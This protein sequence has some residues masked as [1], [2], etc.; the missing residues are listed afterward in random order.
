MASRTPLDPVPTPEPGRR[1]KRRREI[2]ADDIQILPIEEFTRE[3]STKGSYLCYIKQLVQFAIDN[4]W[5]SDLYPH[6]MERNNL[7]TDYIQQMISNPYAQVLMLRLIS[8][9]FIKM[10]DSAVRV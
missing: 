4:G 9:P 2:N 10:D 1:R 5:T 8:N 7:T 3:E 6:A